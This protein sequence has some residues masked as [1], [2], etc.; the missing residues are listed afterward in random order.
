MGDE[1]KA[2]AVATILWN[3]LSPQF[4]QYLSGPAGQMIA[5]SF[6][7]AA[8]PAIFSVLSQPVSV[9]RVD[10]S[11]DAAEGAFVTV[12]TTIPQLLAELNDNVLDLMEE[13]SELKEV[14]RVHKNR[15][16]T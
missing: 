8:G 13:V 1:L 3:R 15:K 14:M 5:Q 2:E 11:E 6:A 12:K 4:Q 9:Q 7:R 10:D 16:K